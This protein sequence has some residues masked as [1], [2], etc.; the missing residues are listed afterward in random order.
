MCHSGA[1]EL[2]R[3]LAHVADE[4]E[5]SALH[6]ADQ[7]LVLAGIT[8]GATLIRLVSASS[9]TTRP[10]QTACSNSSLVTTRS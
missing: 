10:S 5:A 3:P 2:R 4:P 8:D 1:L 9:E 6:C 7:P